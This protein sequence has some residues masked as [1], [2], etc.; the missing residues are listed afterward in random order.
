MS[1]RSG[2]GKVEGSRLAAARNRSR[3]CPAGQVTPWMSASGPGQSSVKVVGGD[4]PQHFLHGR[5]RAPGSSW[6]AA[7]ALGWVQSRWVPRVSRVVVVSAPG[8]D[9]ENAVR[10]EVLAVLPVRVSGGQGG[11][12]VIARAAARWSSSSAK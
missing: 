8:E 1:N 6:S 9:E 2:S 5:G 7:T 10:E 11:H 12:Q 3:G 4:Q